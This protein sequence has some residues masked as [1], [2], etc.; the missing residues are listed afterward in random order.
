MTKLY[1]FI[2]EAKLSE[3][4]VPAFRGAIARAMGIYAHP[5]MHNHDKEGLRFAYPLVQ[6]K[7][8][9]G[10]PAIVALGDVGS[11]LA[12]Y[13]ES[14][15]EMTLILHGK[16]RVFK[17]SEANFCDYSPLFDNSPKYYSLTHYL[18]LTD[19]NV[20]EYRSLMALTDKICFL[21]KI[22]TGNVLSFF[23]G[24]GYTAK[25]QIETVITNIDKQDVIIYKGVHFMAFDLHFVS[26]LELPDSIGLGKSS[27]VGMGIVCRETLPEQFK[28]Y[29][30]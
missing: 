15:R 11:F 2:F 23:K 24:I 10:H 22:L 16:K 8:L 3:N 4:T 14:H 5:L 20:Q 12:Q 29:Q 25:E 21:E 13:F 6:Y 27:S 1:Q 28:H 19:S 18:P 17:L 9:N 7:V 30:S 26:N